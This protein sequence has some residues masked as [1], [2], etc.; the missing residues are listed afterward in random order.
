MFSDRFP[1]SPPKHGFGEWASEG[2]PLIIY[3][4]LFGGGK[5][6]INFIFRIRKPEIG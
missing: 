4:G 3:H 1:P 5:L 6:G 2:Y